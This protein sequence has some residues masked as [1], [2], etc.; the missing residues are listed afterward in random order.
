MGLPSRYGLP[1]Q[2]VENLVQEAYAKVLQK[3]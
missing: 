3:R 2:V 1:Q